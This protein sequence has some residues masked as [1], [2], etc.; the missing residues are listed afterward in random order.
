MDD[1]RVN[2]VQVNGILNACC[3]D[4]RNREVVSQSGGHSQK[5]RCKACGRNHFVMLAH[6]GNMGVKGTAL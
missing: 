4:K 3:G 5:Q 6:R 2:P 1:H